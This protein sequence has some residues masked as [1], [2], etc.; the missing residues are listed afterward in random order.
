MSL[1][2]PPGEWKSTGSRYVPAMTIDL[3][4]S[5]ALRKSPSTA[6][7][8]TQHSR[9]KSAKMSAFF[10]NRSAA[11]ALLAA[12]DSPPAPAPWPFAVSPGDGG[13]PRSLSSSKPRCH[14]LSDRLMMARM[15]SVWRT[16][17]RFITSAS[18][19][20]MVAL[21]TKEAPQRRTTRGIRRCAKER[22]VTKRSKKSSVYP[23]A[24]SRRKSS[25]SSC[26]WDT[27]RRF[28][29]TSFFLSSSMTCVAFFF[30][31]RAAVSMRA[32]RK[33]ERT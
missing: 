19:Q 3:P 28:S 15:W 16:E 11:P 27:S 9:R 17:L 30:G 21:P 14:R 31:T 6:F 33:R 1:P 10:L 20:P 5:I 32:R 2:T 23:L 26:R 8:T 7:R 29:S 12:L 4:S 18:R 25:A 24:R 13:A 22:T